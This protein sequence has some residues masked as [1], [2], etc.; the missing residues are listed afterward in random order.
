MLGVCYSVVPIDLRLQLQ[1]CQQQNQDAATYVTTQPTAAVLVFSALRTQLHAHTQ[2]ACPHKPTHP[3]GIWACHVHIPKQPL[4]CAGFD[5][6]L[7]AAVIIPLPHAMA[8][9]VKRQLHSA[10]QHVG[11]AARQY[12][13]A[14]ANRSHVPHGLLK[15]PGSRQRMAGHLKAHRQTPR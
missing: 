5:T 10:R 6:L 12:S 15:R 4:H 7:T 2:G 3:P 8:C 14:A 1:P 9:E 13:A 11:D